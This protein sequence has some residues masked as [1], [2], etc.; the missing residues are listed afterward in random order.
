MKNPAEKVALVTGGA[1]G[2][3][4]SIVKRLVVEQAHCVIAD[5]KVSEAQALASCLGGVAVELDVTDAGS[6]ENA[7]AYAVERFGRLDIMVNNAGV[8]SALMLTHETSAD[9]WRNV[10]DVDLT[11]V[12]HGMKFAVAQFLKQGGGGTIINISSV[13]GI[14]GIA[15]M[16]PYTAAKAGVNMMTRAA[17]REYGPHG[18][19]VNAVAPTAVDT[20][21]MRQFANSTGDGAR[22]IAQ[23]E[24]LVP[25][26]GLPEPED[27]AAAVAFL[28]SEDAGFI[29]G[30][31]LPVDGDHS[32]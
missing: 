6:M 14:V 3:G 9:T 13:M 25:L 19:R 30:V 4:A 15:G 10:L 7:I 31:V 20:P 17:A 12:F 24:S 11:G 23:L 21:L 26:P 29:N 5:L 1:S 18:I 16:A 32:A 22:M 28:A 2:I 8:G 27:I